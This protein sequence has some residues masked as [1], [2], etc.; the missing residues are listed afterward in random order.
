MC[1]SASPCEVGF[2][3]V[4]PG[5]AVRNGIR[6]CDLQ[7]RSFASLC[8]FYRAAAHMLESFVPPDMVRG[9]G[10]RRKA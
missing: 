9:R 2:G 10:S 4:S 8:L 3:D 7:I 6:C 5:F 1:A